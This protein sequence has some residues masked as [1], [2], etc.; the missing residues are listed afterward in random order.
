MLVYRSH[1]LQARSDAIQRALI[2]I[3]GRQ[4]N[5]D[6]Y[7]NSAMAA[8]FLAGALENTIVIA[9]RFASAAGSE[10]RD[11]L[12]ENELNW[13]CGGRQ[14]WRNGAGAVGHGHVTSFHVTDELL[15][16]LARRE[17][18]P[19]LRA[20]VI[21]GH[22]AGGQYTTR[23]AMANESHD[24]VGMSLRYVVANP[25]SYTYP[26]ALRPTSSAASPNDIAPASAKPQAPFQAFADA[27]NCAAFDNWP[28]GMRERVGYSARF[29][30][31]QLIKQL[32]SRPTT[33]LVGELD[34][35]PNYNFDASCAAMAQGP[36]RVARGLAYARHLKENFGARHQVLVVPACGHN[37]R[38]MFRNSRVLPLLFPTD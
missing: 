12:A 38:C 11:M 4:R 18:F 23:Y 6:G 31:E 15:Q 24:R 20:V 5:A 28:Y 29:P 36:T 27:K 9:P 8:A 34:V 13:I 37:G 22:S 3:H 19:N 25:S 33:F 1:S 30:T 17:L 35:L 14:S 16:R 2:V 10:C 26:D 32:T 7:Y 21:A